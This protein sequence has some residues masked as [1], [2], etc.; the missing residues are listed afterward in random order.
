MTPVTTFAGKKVA[1]FGLGGSGLATTRA[2]VQGG[3]EVTAWDDNENARAKA[4]ASGAA[5]EDLRIAD[6]SEFS[7]LVLAPGVPLTHPKPHWTV[8][9]AQEAGIEII[10]DIELFCR[11]RAARAPKSPFIAI[12]G[13]NGKSTTTALTAHILRNAGMDVQIGGNFGPPILSLEPPDDD[14]FHVIECSSFQIDLTPSINPTVG[15][16]INLSPDHIDR[17][18]TMDN[19]AAS[20]TRLARGAEIAFVAVDDELSD[21]IGRTLFENADG[22]RRVFPV[23]VQRKLDWGI[24]LDGAN[25]RSNVGSDVVL[26]DLTGI[27]TL[28]G[29]HNAQNAAFALGAVSMWSFS[30]DTLQSG[31]GSFPGLAHRMEEVGRIDKAVF[32]NDSKAT[33]A[34]AAEKALLSFDDIYWILGGTPK[35]GGIESLEHLFPKIRK[36]FLIGASAE[37]FARTLD[38]KVPYALCGTLEVAVTAAAADALESDAV[39]PVVLLSPACASYDQF[40]NFEVRGASFRDLVKALVAKYQ[41]P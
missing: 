22:G 17:H 13:T 15:I 7:A 10:G 26:G 38:G 2:L 11:E 3:A 20:K 28:R 34:D 16:L 29:L 6:W 40:P 14:R 41:L 8:E 1:L 33:N 32:I 12:T 5:V 19:Y 30:P 31:L 39:E 36:A 9:K 23:S 18:G 37:D 21:R 4:L 24:S 35:E 27:R 25:I